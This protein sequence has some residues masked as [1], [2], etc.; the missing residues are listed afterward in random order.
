MA[1]YL[2]KRY[3]ARSYDGIITVSWFIWLIW[4]FWLNETNQ[5]NQI[6]QINKTG[7]LLPEWVILA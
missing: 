5:M 6:N 2:S 4:F 3:Q 1:W 7:L